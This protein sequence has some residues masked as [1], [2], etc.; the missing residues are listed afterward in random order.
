VLYLI[1]IG[2]ITDVTNSV[3]TTTTQPSSTSSN[4]ADQ[5]P[6]S[7]QALSTSSP[8]NAGAIAGGVV[9]GVVFLVA[10]VVGIWVLLRRR[11]GWKKRVIDR[12]TLNL[13][14]D[15][16]PTPFPPTEGYTN[17]RTATIATPF[18]VARTPY[19]HVRLGVFSPALKLTPRY[20]L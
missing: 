17:D 19:A 2:R 6:P 12:N 14:E 18:S 4:S 13:D 16:Y 11:H 1:H 20:R 10:A 8:S 3:T 9:G 7:N 15:E 5:N